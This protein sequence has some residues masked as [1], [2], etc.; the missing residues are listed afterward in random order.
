MSSAENFTQCAIFA[1]PKWNVIGISKKNHI[2][3]QRMDWAIHA[4]KKSIFRSVGLTLYGM[5]FLHK[6]VRKN[7]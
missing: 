4:T 1:C 2:V 7:T 3:S 6:I 5:S